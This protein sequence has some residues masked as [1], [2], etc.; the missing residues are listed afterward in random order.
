LSE[1]T[2]TLV[3]GTVFMFY[4]KKELR[5]PED[6]AS[7]PVQEPS[8][9]NS[10]VAQFPKNENTEQSNNIEILGNSGDRPLR[11]RYAVNPKVIDKTKNF[12]LLATGYQDT[13]GTI[14]DVQNHV[15][16]GHALC[17][18]LLGGNRRA[19]AN[20]LGSNWLLLDIDNSVALT[21]EAGKTV[22]DPDGK[23]IAV[24]ERQLTIDDALAN[25][26]IRTHCALIYTTASST[27][28]WNKLR[29]VFLLPEYVQGSEAVEEC[30]R[31]LMEILPHDP[32]C[33][34]S[35]RV[36]YGNTKAQFPLINPRATLPI[37]WVE[38]ARI[39]AQ[40]KKLEFDARVAA[41]AARKKEY[42]DRDNS[43]DWD[44]DSLVQQALS[45]I[46][47][48]SPG[49]NNY[50]ESLRVLMALV[51]HYG[52][53]EA[54][55]IAEGWSP[56]IKGTTWN[57]AQKIRSFRRGNGVSIGS[58]FHIAKTYG[59]RFPT[60]QSPTSPL[61]SYQEPDAKEYGDYLRWEGEQE[62]VEEAEAAN[63]FAGSF[64]RLVGRVCDR[65]AAGF[66]KKQEKYAP[67]DKE[68][69]LQPKGKRIRVILKGDYSSS[70]KKQLYLIP[71]TEY[72]LFE[73]CWI[74]VRGQLA[75]IESLSFSES[76]ACTALIAIPS[77]EVLLGSDDG[78]SVLYEC[79][80]PCETQRQEIFLDEMLSHLEVYDHE[81]GLYRQAT[82]IAD[83][84]MSFGS[85]SR[86]L[87]EGTWG[88]YNTAPSLKDSDVEFT[89]TGLY[90]DDSAFVFGQF[91]K[92]A[93]HGEII[94]E[95]LDGTTVQL[96]NTARI[97]AIWS[98]GAWYHDARY[99]Y[100]NERE[101][102]VVFFE[103]TQQTTHTYTPGS[104]PSYEKYVTS[105]APKIKFVPEERANLLKELASKKYQ[106]VSDTS[107]PGSGKS[108]AI[109]SLQPEDFGVQKIF[110]ASAEHRNPTVA[111][112]ETEYVDLPTRIDGGKHGLIADPTKET[113]SGSPHVRHVKSG[114]R[115][116]L[117]GN[118]VRTG[119]FIETAAKGYAAEM[120]AKASV[121]A[122]C[123][124]CT[125]EQ[126]CPT[127][128]YV[129]G[130]SGF[131]Y[132][133]MEAMRSPKIRCHLD[134]LPSA[135]DLGEGKLALFIDEIG[136]QLKP[137]E[138]IEVTA[139]DLDKTLVTVKE[140]LPEVY[141]LVMPEV[142]PSWGYC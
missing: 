43:G 35:S 121:N 114:E 107:H 106:F 142:A 17:A 58:L 137:V 141:D 105:G 128:K 77:K 49:S 24:Y 57:I 69:F 41:I 130:A 16:Q 39:T 100:C 85:S 7:N 98:H 23:A 3:V 127:P 36:F 62:R 129:Q 4:H 29:L 99:P 104:L 34:D 18:G 55:A 53:I 76:R 15:A 122:A 40:Q 125:Y 112:I 48:R 92:F 52:P 72:A 47:S 6:L 94:F 139:Q 59:F 70:K 109:A 66:A 74:K 108:H 67:V 89:G 78:G 65:V 131:R 61:P 126:I 27:P 8:S 26:F 96:R 75:V 136:R 88:F 118:C 38:E 133:R 10:T 135:D 19:K 28:E 140:K 21:D 50:S 60:P 123:Q 119:I 95:C 120:G 86:G 115:A 14:L 124:S 30:T 117:P 9:T 31:H 90:P 116:S 11:F 87:S 20:V 110:Y 103:N 79:L 111:G 81:R 132:L 25:E 5:V 51:D 33:K 1:I 134:S 71:G 97:T 101:K 84:Y 83:E 44:T 22:K 80:I 37:E 63:D 102:H 13:V 42:Q 73:G 45:F 93:E 64:K 46:P 113:A 91:K 68:P 56:S 54:E 138:L 2:P 82:S 12:E 32:S